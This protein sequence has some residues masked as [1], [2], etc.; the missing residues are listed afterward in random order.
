MSPHSFTKITVALAFSALVIAV[1]GD[2]LAAAS[3][4]LAQR[5]RPTVTTNG[6]S[7][8]SVTLVKPGLRPDV[9]ALAQDPRPAVTTN[10]RAP[11]S[12]TFVK[13]NVIRIVGVIADVERASPPTVHIA[14]K[15]AAER[16]IHTDEHTTYLKWITHKTSEHATT[17]DSESL[18]AGRCVAVDI[19]RGGTLAKTVRISDEPAGSEFDPCKNRR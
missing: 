1:I 17:A 19:P 14:S 15:G 12:V 16:A 9:S 3:S 6:K 8:T 5:A 13:P 18:V 2:R 11:S 10:G 7:P 4:A